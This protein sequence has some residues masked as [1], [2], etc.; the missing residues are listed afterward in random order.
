[1]KD[2]KFIDKAVFLKKEKILIIADLHIGYE[3]SLVGKG[4]FLPRS[5]YKTI[6]ENI[7]GILKKTGRVKEVVVLG[8]LKHEFSGILS[9]EWQEVIDFLD[10]LAEFCEKIVLVKGNHDTILGPIAEKKG[11]EVR[12]FYIQGENCFFHGNKMFPEVLKSRVKRIFFGHMHPAITIKED[13]KAETYKCFLVGKWKSKEI[14]ILPSFFPL[15]EGTDVEIGDTNLALPLKFSGF[16]VYVPVP[17]EEKVLDL[18]K[19]KDVGRLKN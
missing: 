19:V 4:V 3:E 5:Q 18:G 14:I 13:V 17:D 6:K 12:D 10:F 1:M 11:L 7:E 8:D 9:Q 2:Y 16:E 15:T